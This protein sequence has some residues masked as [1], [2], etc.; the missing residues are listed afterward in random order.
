MVRRRAASDDLPPMTMDQ[1]HA[2][3]RQ[4]GEVGDPEHPRYQQ[5]RE[6]VIEA[7][8]KKL[9]PGHLKTRERASALFDVF[10]KRPDLVP[11][12]PPSMALDTRP[13]LPPSIGPSA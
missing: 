5:V 10:R 1:A 9:P 8:Y 11:C 2:V 4:L 7:I 13:W 3:M 12:P 6:R